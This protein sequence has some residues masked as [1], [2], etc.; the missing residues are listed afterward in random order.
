M[1]AKDSPVS[2]E[3]SKPTFDEETS[4]H[5]ISGKQDRI[6]PNNN[7]LSNNV[8]TKKVVDGQTQQNVKNSAHGKSNKLDIGSSKDFEINFFHEE[9]AASLQ[10]RAF[11]TFVTEFDTNKLSSGLRDKKTER[12]EALEAEVEKLGVQLKEVNLE[13][14]EITSKY[15]K[16]SAICRSQR[17]E[18]Q[19]LK[20]ALAARTPSPSREGLR[21]SPSVP[22]S[23][24]T[25]IILFCNYFLILVTCRFFIGFVCDTRL[26]LLRYYTRGRRLVGQF[27]N[28]SKIKLNGKLL[29]R[30]QSHGKLFQRNPSHKSL[31]QLT[32][33]PNL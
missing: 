18:I 26:Y 20:Q 2:E 5:H 28:C 15:E 1:H 29:V 13:K 4:S 8:S 32:T 11:S 23:A 17:Q 31:F 22:S 33:D 12:E 7:Q 9:N 3:E 16:L 14:A 24:A 21:T 19:D 6:H 25:V 27:G 30:S 10:D